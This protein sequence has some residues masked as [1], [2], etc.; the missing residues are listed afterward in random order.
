MFT[1]F[2]GRELSMKWWWPLEGVNGSDFVLFFKYEL[3]ASPWTCVCT[4]GCLLAQSCP[5]LCEPM[6]CSPPGFSVHGILQAKKTGVSLPCP[7]PGN[8]PNP[9]IEPSSP[10]LQA[11]SLLSEPPELNLFADECMWRS[12][13]RRGFSW[14]WEAESCMKGGISPS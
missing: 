7:S 10:A 5:T 4:V 13:K 8:L 9:G 1:T 6:D 2:N 14:E 3:N 11:D 12:D